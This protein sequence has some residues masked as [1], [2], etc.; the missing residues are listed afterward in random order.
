M[1]APA[2]LR[3][4]CRSSAAMSSLAE[5]HQGRGRRSGTLL[6]ILRWSRLQALPRHGQTPATVA[7]LPSTRRSHQYQ[8]LLRSVF[9]SGTAVLMG[10]RRRRRRPVI[11]VLRP[12]VAS[13]RRRNRTGE[14]ATDRGRWC[15]IY[16]FHPIH[17]PSRSPRRSS[18]IVPMACLCLHH[19]SRHDG[20]LTSSLP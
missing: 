6:R 1:S 9:L 19:Q 3:L 16:S 2:H 18:R 7:S 17:H 10:R 4:P 20:W 12:V 5:H 14:Q 8:R 15:G 13:L 11:L